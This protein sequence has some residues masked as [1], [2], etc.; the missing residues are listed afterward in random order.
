MNTNGCPT[1]AKYISQKHL[2]P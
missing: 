2:I 1:H